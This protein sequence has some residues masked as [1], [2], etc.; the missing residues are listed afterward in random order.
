MPSTLNYQVKLT[1][2]SSRG[3]TVGEWKKVG[4]RI[5]RAAIGRSKC[6]KVSVYAGSV[7]IDVNE[8]GDLT[9]REDGFPS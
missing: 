4:T 7:Q 6:R 9:I 5:A 3:L 1:I 2:D 8:A